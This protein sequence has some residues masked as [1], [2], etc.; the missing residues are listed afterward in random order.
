MYESF[1]ELMSRPFPSTP[2][3]AAYFPSAS[4]EEAFALIK[5]ALRDGESVAVLFGPAGIGKTLLAHRLIETIDPKNALVFLNN[6]NNPSVE[7]MLQAIAHDASLP[8]EGVT[9]Q[10]LRM[11]LADLFMERFT[12]G[13]K[14]IIIIDEAQNLSPGQLEELRLFTN[15]EG[16]SAKAV[17]I[18]LIG[19]ERL[20]D[21]LEHQAVSGLSQRIAVTAQLKPLTDEETIEFVRCQIHR[22]GGSADSIFTAS[23]LSEICEYAGGI[24]RR[25][26]QLCHRAL[27]L[28]YAHQCGTIDGEY[29]ELA[30]SQLFLVKL[31]DRVESHHASVGSGSRR[32]F[33]DLAF[34]TLDRWKSRP[35]QD[36][37]GARESA[38]GAQDEWDMLRRPEESASE[39]EPR[40]ES[41][42]SGWV[43]HTAEDTQRKPPTDTESSSDRGNSARS[44]RRYS[45]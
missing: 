22:V 39:L 29:V 41:D 12:E 27:M 17:Q 38:T 21:N 37:A 2:D 30:A 8:F 20:A 16:R 6:I 4:H 5:S 34:E 13:T 35:A 26:N 43:S 9:E 18:L 36:N 28:A 40:S 3:P 23:A 10:M 25:M 24:P 11:R 19:Q 33:Q 42:T 31:E 15:L 45:S 32:I 14:T 1:F 44:R 7:S